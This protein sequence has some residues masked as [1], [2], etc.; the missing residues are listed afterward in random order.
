MCKG[1]KNYNSLTLSSIE[2][3]ISFCIPNNNDIQNNQKKIF[4]DD[5]IVFCDCGEDFVSDEFIKFFTP[6]HI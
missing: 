1:V 4:T 3:Y 5:I 2:K 6:L